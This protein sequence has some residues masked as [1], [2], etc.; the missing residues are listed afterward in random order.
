VLKK[1]LKCLTTLTLLAGCYFGY[2]HAFAI[3]VEQLRAIKRTDNLAFRVHDSKSLL[4]SI[5]YATEACG[6]GHWA[7]DK[8]LAYRY[9]NAERGYW[10]YAKE[11]IR[12]VEENGVRYDG[13]RMRMKPFLL[14]TKSRDGKNTKTITADRAVFDLNAPLSFD[15][16]SGREPLKIKHAHLEPN[17]VIRDDK[18]TPNDPKDD[19]YTEPITTVDYEES[20]QQIN[21]E[22]DT[23]VVMRDPGMTAIGDGML[24]QLRKTDPTEAGGSSGFEGVE[25]LDLLK[26][27]VVIIRDVGNSGLLPGPAQN[28]KAG[29]K[30]GEAT[31]AV[32]SGPDQKTAQPPEPVEP[33]PL[34]LTCDSKMQIFV[35]KSKLPVLVGP[36]EA[37]VPTLAQFERNVVVLRGDPNDQPDQLTCDNLR[38]TLVPGEKPDQKETVT[39]TPEA[40][41]AKP[42][43]SLARDDSNSQ[44][45]VASQAGGDAN[46]GPLSGLTLQRLHATGHAVWLIIP[47]NGVKLRCNE[48]IHARRLP[49][50][51]DMTYF[52]GDRTRPVEIVK[53]DVERDED[54]DGEP[55]EGKVTSVTNIWTEDATLFDSGTGTD[56]ADI[57]AHGPGRLETR[58]DR[59][60]PVERIAIWQDTLIV[61]NKLGPNNELLHKVID[62]T[63]NRPCFIDNLQKTSLDSA[64]WIQ[65]WLKPKPAPPKG[66]DENSAALS[67]GTTE[68]QTGATAMR[69]A[70]AD[71]PPRSSTGRQST[72]SKEKDSEAETKGGGLQIEQLHAIVDV[73]LLA[74][75]KTMTAR[76]TF[77]A[78]FIDAEPSKVASASPAKSRETLNPDSPPA[79]ETT[80]PD[81]A[82]EQGREQMTA[83]DQAEKPSDDPPM[84]GSCDRLWA[85]VVLK[86]KPESDRPSNKQTGHTKTAAAKPANDETNAEIRKVWM[87]GNVALHQDPKKDKD[88]PRNTSNEGGTDASGEALYLDNRGTNLA[89]VFVYQRDPI[90][91]EYLPGPLPPA[92]VESRD[93]DPMKITGAGSIKL[94]Q[95][96]DQAWVFGP[97]TLTQL[98]ARGFL[99]DKAPGADEDANENAPDGNADRQT[100][101]ANSQ[102]MIR[103]TAA[104]RNDIPDEQTT[105]KEK[106]D[107]T[108]P[109]TRAGVPL[110][111]KVPMTIG[112]SEDMQFTGRS[113]DPEGRPAGRA[114]FHGIVT[115]QMEDALLHCTEKMIAFTDREVPLTQVGKKNQKR[116][117][118]RAGTEDD[119]AEPQ[120]ELSLIFCYRNAVGISRKVDPEVPLPIQQ[121]RIEG[122]Q[123]LAYD[124]RTGDFF[125]PGKGK[126]FLYDRGDKP[127]ET[128]E[129]DSD[130]TDV[131]GTGDRQP[132]PTDGQL[133]VTQTSA[134]TLNRSREGISTRTT[135]AP[136]SGQ[137]NQRELDAEPSASEI[138]TMVLT[139]IHFNN[140]M[141]GRLGSGKENDKT[142][143]RWSEFYGNVEAFRAKVPNA[144]AKLNPDRLPLDGVFLTGQT[145]RVIQEPPPVGSPESAPA[146][147]YLKTWERAQAISHDK[148]INAD[149]IT[150]D[151]YKDLVYAYGEDGHSVLFAEQHAAGLPISPGSAEAVQLNPKTGGI[152]LINSNTVGMIDKNTGYRPTA[153]TP[154]DPYAKKKKKIKTPFKLPTMNVERRGWTGQ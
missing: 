88:K 21:T 13:K 31:T 66:V 5:R 97:G 16:N 77:D 58:P 104:A 39:A 55:A 89:T 113:V 68:G 22:L 14:I 9:Y 103:T 32:A 100:G 74:P 96:T 44:G 38:L 99:T 17:V 46:E 61:K 105:S 151:S 51:P 87:F 70:S 71:Q 10:I 43:E 73:H 106:A 23:H 25:R 8:E 142:E 20:T 146:R 29:P 59:D 27:V 47:A 110:S 116:S 2:V 114:D 129:P 65:V 49:L 76:D 145:L 6:A 35:P 90:E 133:T 123:L 121:Q 3:V 141:R 130:G 117:D 124:R 40:N 7:A 127:A 126:V 83:Q 119:E 60:Q 108:K 136:R 147:Q 75:S 1:L 28:K 53:I 150:Y 109:K 139:Q 12:V 152:R 19:M 137:P 131:D 11:C 120:A 18:G 67:N 92:S 111:E 101:S 149:V 45:T 79:S 154:D 95:E 153:S 86:P 57:Y 62:L 128:Q 82:N 24:M 134:K 36:Q 4:D 115:A 112:F 63:G 26:N 50:K 135:G 144:Q 122:D 81:E 84:T 94:N 72:A 56:A 37:P 80:A 34:H 15:A 98:A 78:E 41:P 93:N 48:M 54:E 52:R 107:D 148:V 125:I 69:I 140:G 132:A 91:K 102:V 138:P 30:K 143:H 64:S 118:G 42:T 85:R 33:T